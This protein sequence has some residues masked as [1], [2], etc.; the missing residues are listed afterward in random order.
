MIIR[1]LAREVFGKLFQAARKFHAR[2]KIEKVAASF[3]VRK[4]MPDIP[5]TIFASDVWL[6]IA[7]AHH[8]RQIVGHRQDRSALP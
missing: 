1:D 3:N 8:L 2:S 5:C 4:A 7:T 6:Q